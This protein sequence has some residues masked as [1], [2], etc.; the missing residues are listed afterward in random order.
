MTGEEALAAFYLQD[1][2]PI[3]LAWAASRYLA[4]AWE[5]LLRG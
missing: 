5:G 2:E 1:E 4:Y 3:P